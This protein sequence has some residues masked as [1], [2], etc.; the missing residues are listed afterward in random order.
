VGAIAC[1]AAVFRFAG[2]E[3]FSSRPALVLQFLLV[4]MHPALLMWCTGLRWTTWFVPLFLLA[5]LWVRRDAPSP[6]RFW[7]VLALAGLGLFYLNYLALLLMPPLVLVALRRRNATQEWRAIA[8]S[9]A[10]AAPFV[11]YQLYMLVRFQIGHTADQRSGP[12]GALAG[13][14]QGIAIHPG[15]FPVSI[16]GIVTLAAFAALSCLLLWRERSNLQRDPET[17]LAGGSIILLALTGL[18][19][20]WRNLVPLVPLLF[21]KFVPSLERAPSRLGMALAWVLALSNLIGCINVAQHRDTNKGSWNLPVAETVAA[22]RAAAASCGTGT[23]VIA[24]FDPVLAANLAERTPFTVIGPRPTGLPEPMI[25]DG[26]YC[27]FQVMTNPGAVPPAIYADIQHSF[28]IGTP[29]ARIGRDPQAA[30]KRRLEPRTPEY[31]VELHGYGHVRRVPDYLHL[32]EKRA[33]GGTGGA[34]GAFD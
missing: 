34:I 27:L 28:P 31:Y 12:L 4:V 29:L 20:K 15:I 32:V 21:A 14:V 23:P 5:I 11:L 2:L 17:W 26:D 22:T 30:I 7:G 16:L 24:V 3:R 9:A 18:S 1:A 10:V 25:K 13:L 19:G 6:W 33:K 8:V